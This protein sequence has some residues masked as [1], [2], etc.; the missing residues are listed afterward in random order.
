MNDSIKIFIDGACQPNPGNGGIGIFVSRGINEEK[1]FNPWHRVSLGIITINSKSPI[2]YIN[3]IKH[4]GGK[5]DPKRWWFYFAVPSKTSQHKEDYI[6]V[7]SLRKKSLPV[8]GNVKSIYW[9]SNKNGKILADK[10]KQDIDI[11]SLSKK[12]GNLKVQSLHE[13]FS[14]YSIELE[15]NRSP[16]PL[17]S[18]PNISINQEQ[19]TTLNKI[20]K[21]CID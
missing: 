18:A 12:L 3:I 16:I 17:I 7:K 2:K 8:I 5:N 19:W 4:F 11:N 20:A 21:L 6:E 9:K 15:F 10:F 14:G 13:N 1:L